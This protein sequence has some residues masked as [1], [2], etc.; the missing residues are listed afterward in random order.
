M[1]KLA[2][3]EKRELLDIFKKERSY[4]RCMI[5]KSLKVEADKL[6]A[7]EDGIIEDLK[8]QLNVMENK[9]FEILENE[10]FNNLAPTRYSC[11][12]LKEHPTLKKFDR[13]TNDTIQSIIRG[14]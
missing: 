13:D 11:S 6:T 7:I 1:V 2:Q 9:K 3:W 8:A 4:E 12:E 10:G 5:A 14:V